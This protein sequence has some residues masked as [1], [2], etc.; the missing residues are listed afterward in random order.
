VA[1][2]H[3]TAAPN[4]H[5]ISSRR[6]IAITSSASDRGGALY[7]F[8]VSPGAPS[9]AVLFDMPDRARSSIESP[10]RNPKAF[11]LLHSLR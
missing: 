2:G 3:I 9:K 1:S 6:L 4:T 7:P 5:L 10:A 11:G 8:V